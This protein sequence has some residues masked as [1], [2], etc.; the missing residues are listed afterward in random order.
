MLGGVRFKNK[1]VG[2]ELQEI[3]GFNASVTL[4]EQIRVQ[5]IRE[6]F[7]IS[8]ARSGYKSARAAAPSAWVVTMRSRLDDDRANA[9]PGLHSSALQRNE[10]CSR[11][12]RAFS[13]RIRRR[14]QWRY[15]QR[16][17]R[18]SRRCGGDARA[19]NSARV[20]RRLLL[21]PG[22]ARHGLIRPERRKVVG[23]EDGLRARS[24]IPILQT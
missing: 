12:D 8:E 4:F 1:G 5:E 2:P 20:Q 16:C 3:A 11:S 15:L 19:G 13:T 17:R 24:T 21:Q 6:R 23:P 22:P 7:Q 14:I 9:H 10:P 18:Q